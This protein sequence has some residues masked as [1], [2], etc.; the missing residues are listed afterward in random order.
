VG[1]RSDTIKLLR[2]SEDDERAMALELRAMSLTLTIVVLALRRPLPRLRNPTRKSGSC[3]QSCSSLRR[4]PTSPPWRSSTVA[5]RR[6]HDEHP[7]IA[8]VSSAVLYLHRRATSLGAL[9]GVSYVLALA[10]LR[11]RS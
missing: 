10:V 3:T 6:S 11:F 8:L 4:R 7:A 2:G 9:A 5:A 1:G